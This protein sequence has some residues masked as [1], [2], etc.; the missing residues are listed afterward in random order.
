[1]T[2]IPAS[3]LSTSDL[4]VLGNNLT[5]AVRKDHRQRRQV[6]AVN[7]SLAVCQERVGRLY[8]RP[9]GAG[10]WCSPGTDSVQ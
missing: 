1:M 5:P 8:P 7:R 2:I 10:H 6:R 9:A 3:R 4:S